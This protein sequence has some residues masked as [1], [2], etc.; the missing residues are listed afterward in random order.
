MNIVTCDGSSDGTTVHADPYD[1]L[2]RVRRERDS[3]QSLR[4]ASELCVE[5]EE[6]IGG[7]PP[8]RGIIGPA[9]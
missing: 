2:M 5:L 6:L 7:R 9:R 1:T 3:A 4:E 8:T